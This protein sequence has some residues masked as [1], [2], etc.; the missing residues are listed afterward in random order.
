ML[1]KSKIQLV[2]ESLEL[3]NNYKESLNNLIDKYMIEDNIFIYKN[4]QLF[5]VTEGYFEIINTFD[6]IHDAVKECLLDNTMK[7][8]RVIKNSTFEVGY[9]KRLLSECGKDSKILDI[10]RLE[11]VR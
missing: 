1:T 7:G 11:K 3:A 8:I 9:I 2:R 10:D 6:N 4:N 5:E